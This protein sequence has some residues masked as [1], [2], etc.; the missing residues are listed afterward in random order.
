MDD[1]PERIW[2]WVYNEWQ[3]AWG[4]DEEESPQGHHD[5]ADRRSVQAAGVSCALM[6]LW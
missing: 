1:A 5:C 4:V 3:S 2:A 6:L